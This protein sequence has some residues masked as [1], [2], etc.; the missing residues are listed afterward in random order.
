MLLRRYLRNGASFSLTGL[1][2]VIGMLLS[3]A[4]TLVL[5]Y[6]NNIHN[7][8]DEYNAP[9]AISVTERIPTDTKLTHADIDEVEIEDVFS[10]LAKIR[11]A[12]QDNSLT[13]VMRDHANDLQ[14]SG[15]RLL[16]EDPTQH[17]RPIWLPAVLQSDYALGDDFVVR[18]AASTTTYQVQGFVETIYGGTPGMGTFFVEINRGDEIPDAIP[19]SLIS[20]TGD[21]PADASAAITEALDGRAAEKYQ[22]ALDLVV[23]ITGIGAS[24]FAVIFTAF[25]IIL[26][27]A[28][29]IVLWFVLGNLLR[30]DLPALG[31]LRAGGYRTS[32]ALRP[33]VLAFTVAAFTGAAVGVAVSYLLLPGISDALMQQSGISWTP[34]FSWVT[35]AIA[36]VPVVAIVSVVTALV[37]RRIRTL[38]VLDALEGG[39]ATRGGVDSL[40]L[41][42]ARLPLSEVLGVK[43]SLRQIGQQFALAGCVLAVA[44]ASCFTFT[45]STQLLGSADKASDMLL[46]QIGD[47]AVSAGQET[48]VAEIAERVDG[49]DGIETA[50][51]THVENTRIDG[52]AAL[53]TVADDIEAWRGPIAHQ[54]RLPVND[55]EIAFGGPLAKRFGLEVGDNYTLHWEGGEKEYLVTGIVS[56]VNGIGLNMFITTEGALR[57]NPSYAPSD[58]TILV[59]ED[60]EVADV[61][62][63]L[64]AEFAD[65]DATVSNI[66]DVIGSQVDGFLQMGSVLS[67]VIGVITGSIVTLM[68]SLVVVTLIANNRTQF[69]VFKAIGYTTNQ[70]TRQVVW[71]F[72]PTIF[73]SAVLGAGLAVVG[74]EPIVAEMMQAIGVSR[75]SIDDP[76]TMAVLV[77]VGLTLLGLV[78]CLLTA[79]R[80]RKLRPTDLL[81][82]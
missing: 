34:E 37:A 5:V 45:A 57:V 43:L 29:V 70:L 59:H 2:L 62:T 80:V 20:V 74:I 31:A 18:T 82:A 30:R 73:L 25:S 1:A 76:I 6:P 38:S 64:Q 72:L 56:T 35:A 28:L 21:D 22:D 40:P 10:A 33:F 7:K 19:T 8:T 81:R 44:F 16:R 49:I 54:G 11:F 65:T 39:R 15:R 52:A 78:I 60:V 77:V 75:V 50:V 27:L 67:L 66:H 23:S 53:L 48:T 63:D 32:D 41:D 61:V 51:A 26:A 58:L 17:D 3:I 14:F 9:D 47:I 46:G 71:A 24:V 36:V 69:G 42:R 68:L 79:Q 13:L 12:D 4:A 55:N